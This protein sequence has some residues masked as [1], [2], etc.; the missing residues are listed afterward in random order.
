MNA[1]LFQGER[2]E[3]ELVPEDMQTSLQEG[4]LLIEDHSRP[5]AEIL[6]EQ[7]AQ[8]ERPALFIP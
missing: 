4:G 6:A 3:L 8:E 2:M 7:A 5:A 1:V